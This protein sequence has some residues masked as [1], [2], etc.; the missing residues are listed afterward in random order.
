MYRLMER[1]KK[2][3]KRDERR[4]KEKKKEEISSSGL[5]APQRQSPIY[6]LGHCLMTHISGKGGLLYVQISQ[7]DSPCSAL[8]AKASRVGENPV[9]SVGHWFA[10]AWRQARHPAPT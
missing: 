7:I 9:T 10:N 5:S 8:T 6:F 1:K 2:R 3:G 4:G